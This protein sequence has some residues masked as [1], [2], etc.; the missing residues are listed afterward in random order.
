MENNDI[1][2]FW[3][4]QA[5]LAGKAGSQ[6][7]VAK[8]VEIAALSRHINDGMKVCEFG[9]GNGVTA[10]E[11]AK[12]FDIHMDCFDFSPAM[13]EAARGAA[14]AAGV[15]LRVNFDV[16]DVQVEPPLKDSYDVIYTER[17]LINLQ[18]WKAQARAIQYLVS[19]LSPCGRLLLCEN[20]IQG[21]G[22]LNQL[23]EMVGLERISPPWHNCYLDETAVE[24]LQEHGLKLL[25]VEP[26]SSTY[27]FLSRVVN[28]WL[29][30]QEGVQPAYDA[31][32]NRLALMLPPFGDCAQGK[33]WIF[34][35]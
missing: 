3:N 17:M 24:R 30:K 23:R 15:H 12:R 6:D 1:L 27:Y 35:R 33:L 5:S 32:V 14:K 11:F 9:C 4:K 8:E 16:A 18:T 28:A 10:I 31:P 20:S 26:F 19:K 29:A 2:N 22:K 34:E 7:L 13:I 25:A 21:L